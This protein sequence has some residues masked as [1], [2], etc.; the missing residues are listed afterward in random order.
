LTGERITAA[1]L[2]LDADAV[3]DLFNE[4]GRMLRMLEAQGLVRVSDGVAQRPN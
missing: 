1:R 3:I 2:A 4:L